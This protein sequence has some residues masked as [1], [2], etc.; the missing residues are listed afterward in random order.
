LGVA[1][2]MEYLAYLNLWFY[3]TIYPV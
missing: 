3:P 1:W 2:G